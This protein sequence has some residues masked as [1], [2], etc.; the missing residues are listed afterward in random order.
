MAERLL[1][2]G[3]IFAMIVV[4]HGVRF[5]C[6]GGIGRMGFNTLRGQTECKKR[7]KKYRAHQDNWLGYESCFAQKMPFSFWS[8]RT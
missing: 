4:D 6:C 3:I 2:N 7:A 8:S 5:A 1:D